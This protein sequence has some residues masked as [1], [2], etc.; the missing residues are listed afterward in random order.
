VPPGT[1]AVHN[2]WRWLDALSLNFDDRKDWEQWI[3]KR[4]GKVRVK[5]CY[6]TS[7]IV[8][9]AH[10]HLLPR[11]AALWLGEVCAPETS[12]TVKKLSRDARHL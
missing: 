8:V 12:F 10:K 6:N 4:P 9:A 1:A 2:S 3:F 11:G 7:A 5:A